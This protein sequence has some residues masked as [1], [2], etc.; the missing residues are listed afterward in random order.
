[1]ND[2]FLPAFEAGD[3][4][5]ITKYE[6]DIGVPIFNIQVPSMGRIMQHPVYSKKDADWLHYVQ[7]NPEGA[8]F[9]FPEA[10]LI[11]DE[12]LWQQTQ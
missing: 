2:P 11:R 1:M 7:L 12:S 8:V 10:W 9:L 6:P 3:F 5:I 4:V